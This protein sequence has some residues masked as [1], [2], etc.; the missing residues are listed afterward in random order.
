MQTPLK[1]DHRDLRYLAN[2]PKIIRWEVV[3]KAY[4]K[5]GI[6]KKLTY[7]EAYDLIYDGYDLRI[8]KLESST[9]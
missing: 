5:N 6:E 3:A 2:I 9:S 7:Y 8:R 1:R 4:N